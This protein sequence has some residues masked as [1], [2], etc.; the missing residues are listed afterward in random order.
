MREF[1]YVSEQ[2]LRQFVVGT[3]RLSG[4]V[5]AEGELKVPGVGVKLSP[6]SGSTF[7][8]LAK[9]VDALLMYGSVG[10]LIGPRRRIPAENFEA[11]G[12][13][14]G[15]RFKT[16]I[17]R[18]VRQLSSAED[19]VEDNEEP[20][21]ETEERSLVSATPAAVR[22]LDQLMDLEYTAEWM[23]GFA[24]VTALVPLRSGGRVVAATPL[25]VERVSAPGA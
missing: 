23:A 11:L 1:V 19:V 22:M 13:S 14:S 4:K 20:A 6:G 16:V 7:A 24:R 12:P 10:H 2:K 15:M 21:P 5:K 8:E 17:N 9:V 25:Y 18:L 3:S